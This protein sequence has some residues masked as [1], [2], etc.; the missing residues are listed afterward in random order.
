MGSANC[1]R[2]RHNETTDAV[3]RISNAPA[4]SCSSFT[5]NKRPSSPSSLSSISVVSSAH[6][7]LLIFLLTILIPACDSSYLAFCMMY[8]AY[9][10]NKQ[11]DNIQPVY[12]TYSFSNFEP[13]L[14]SMPISNCYL[15]TSIHVS[16]EI[17][18]MVWYSHV[19]K[20]FPQFVVIHTVKGF[21][22]VNEAEVDTFWKS[23]AFSM[24]QW[25]LAIWSQVPLTFLNPTCC[26]SGSSQFIYRWSLA[27]RIFIIP[28]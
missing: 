13:V 20:N 9:K 18:K 8:S 3:N 26:T 4:F 19:F 10:L 12:F 14:S 25:I 5:L 28:G 7:T 16:Q 1:V 6:L 21:S 2:S 22:V 23:L 17:D 24:I 27:W 11:G 15:L